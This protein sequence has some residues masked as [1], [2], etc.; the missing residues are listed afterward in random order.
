M[1]RLELFL[2]EVSLACRRS[3]E[4]GLALCP[5]QRLFH[6]FSSHSF[7]PVHSHSPSLSRSPC[8]SLVL[9]LPLAVSWEQ[10]GVC[11]SSPLS[12]PLSVVIQLVRTALT[13]VS[14][15]P[16]IPLWRCTAT[17]CCSASSDPAP[18]LM[19]TGSACSV[20][21]TRR[22]Q[23]RAKLSLPVVFWWKA[24]GKRRDRRES[25]TVHHVYVFVRTV[26]GQPV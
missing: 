22:R 9:T 2:S 13:H 5:V 12:P 23:R 10:A 21:M 14:T 3:A 24:W 20:W 19:I 6:T 18:A 15:D 11:V 7:T 25:L 1:G 4:D 26:Q 16:V 8:T 17:S